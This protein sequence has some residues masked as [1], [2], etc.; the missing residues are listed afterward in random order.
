M[1]PKTYFKRYDR[2]FHPTKMVWVEEYTYSGYNWIWSYVNGLP[3]RRVEPYTRVTPGHWSK[4][5]D[6]SV[7]WT[8]KGRYYLYSKYH[9]YRRIRTF[10]ER[11]DALAYPEFVRAKRRSK[12]LP[13][14]WDDFPVQSV[15]SWKD[16]HK[17]R[18]QWMKN[19]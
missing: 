5:K 8:Q 3:V 17:C 7:T 2:E 10:P 12:T 6:Y 14:P 4:R 19:L 11:R 9:Y 16:T 13:N 1:K 15:K 18:K